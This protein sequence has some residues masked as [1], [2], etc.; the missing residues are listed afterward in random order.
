MDAPHNT[1]RPGADEAPRGPGADEA[2]GGLSADEALRATGVTIREAGS[3]DAV[4]GVMPRWVALP[5]STEEVA[6]LMRV[7]AGH[8]LAVVPVGGGTRLHWG[9]PP[10]RCDL[11]VDTCCLNEIP[12]HASGDLV[13]RVQAGVTM[14]SLAETLAARGQELALDVP[15]G[16]S[17][18]GGVLATAVAGP[19]RLRYGT[20]RDLLIGITVVLADGTIARSGGK[21]VKNVAGY[22]LGKLFTGS[23]GTLGIITEAVFRLH[24]ITPARRWITAGLPAP[25]TAATGSEGS[26][27]PVGPGT[28]EGSGFPVS[29]RAVSVALAASQAEP[30]AVEL[31]WLAPS[32]VLTVSALVEGVAAEGRAAAVRDL[33]GG[34]AGE[35]GTTGESGEWPVGSYGVAEGDKAPDWWGVLPGEEVLLE[36]R[37]PPSGVDGALRA[38][39]RRGLPARVRGSLASAVLQVALPPEIGGPELAAFVSGVRGDVGPLGGRLTVLAAPP[40]QAAPVDR[41]GPVGALPL[42]RRVKE[43]FD[44]DRRMSPGRL[45]GGI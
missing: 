29:P 8:D 28:V 21:V 42:M 12:E 4:A 26:G 31:D 40:E 22:D 16:G 14:E 41:W 9:N 17:T 27:S 33:L 44:P 7:S 38:V 39:A 20:A 5:E 24:P 45:A 6:A 36:L 15:V 13:V 1:P 34:T 3:G 11:L 30:S 43:R 23:Y 19:R 32:G 25:R 35:S 18:V 37:V 10:E 2:M